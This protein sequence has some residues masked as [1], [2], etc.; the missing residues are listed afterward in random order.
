MSAI[1]KVAK[2]IAGAVTAFGTGLITAAT[3]GGISSSEWWVI[4]GGTLVGGAAV[5]TVPNK[6]SE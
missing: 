3:D 6:P 4:I 1:A 5:W 2:A